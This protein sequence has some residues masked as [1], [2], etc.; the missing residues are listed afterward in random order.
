[1]GHIKKYNATIC[2]LGNA[3][4]MDIAIGQRSESN[5]LAWERLV[6]IRKDLMLWPPQSPDINPIKNL[7]GDVKRVVATGNATKKAVV[8]EEWSQ[9]ALKRCQDL[10]DSQRRRYEPVIKN[11]GYTTKY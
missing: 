7:W 4:K 11:K 1:M 3:Y 10:I 9:I 8:Q 6:C 2:Q 5:E